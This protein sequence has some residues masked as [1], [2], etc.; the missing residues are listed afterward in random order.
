ME[1]L[2][3]KNEYDIVLPTDF[4]TTTGGTT[5]GNVTSS[6]ETRGVAVK[7]KANVKDIFFGD[8]DWKSCGKA[9]TS[10]VSFEG[11]KRVMTSDV[12]FDAIKTALFSPVPDRCIDLGGAIKRFCSIQ[13]KL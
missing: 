4:E 2:R 12:D 13:V 1:V 11:F 7:K 9:L 5:S 8:I 3:M 6:P 10:D